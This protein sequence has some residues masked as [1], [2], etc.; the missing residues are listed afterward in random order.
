[1][2]KMSSSTARDPDCTTPDRQPADPTPPFA[3]LVRRGGRA[4][5]APVQ[6]A[7]GRDRCAYSASSGVFAAVSGDANPLAD[8]VVFLID[9]DG[10]IQLENHCEAL[11]CRVGATVVPL[12][13]ACEVPFGTTI[14][15]G[16]DELTIGLPS[17]AVA[18]DDAP[19]P[20]DLIALGNALPRTEPGGFVDLTA[21][22]DL[23]PNGDLPLTVL[24]EEP[25]GV[26]TPISPDLD[27]GD[28]LEALLAEY[29][30]ALI[31]RE[32]S[33]A[34]AMKEIEPPQIAVP[35]PPDPFLDT[36]RYRT[37][38]LL[39]DLLDTRQQ[40]DL[41]LGD[42]NPFLSDQFFVDDARHD[43]L[44]LLAPT[45]RRRPHFPPAALLA[46]REHHLV[47]VD[48]HFPMLT[49]FTDTSTTEQHDD[50]RP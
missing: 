8:H 9:A 47:S 1:M 3:K 37:G 35:L 41:V 20:V 46:R 14:T 21:L 12:H 19:A 22:A 43:V 50:E 17:S 32:R 25:L 7:L 30:R 40:I 6:H 29:R 16:V 28:P 15:V 11:A 33:A 10:R 23:Q 4:P 38:S 24:D 2:S 34:H 49:T 27:N 5:R 31:H 48:S 36:E 44:H 42:M 18:Q 26:V 39:N 13:R 45:Q